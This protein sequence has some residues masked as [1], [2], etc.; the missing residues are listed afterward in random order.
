M[1]EDFVKESHILTQIWR[2]PV[3][4]N[5]TAMGVA[6]RSEAM[7]KY[8]DAPVMRTTRLT[9]AGD[10]IDDSGKQVGSNGA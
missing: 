9:T 8:A 4:R 6:P 5:S 3:P 10:G 1:V 2:V 7:E